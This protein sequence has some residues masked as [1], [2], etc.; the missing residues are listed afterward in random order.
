VSE[1]LQ[2]WVGRAESRTDTIAAAP[3]RMLAGT[4]DRDDPEPQ[5][6]DVLPPLWHWLSFLPTPRARETGA[7]GHPRR[8]GFLPPVELP[9]RMWAAGRL[10]WETANPLR[11]G[12]AVRRDSAIVSVQ[13]KEGRSGPLVFVTVRHRLSNGA[14]LA[15]SEEQ[16]IVYRDAPKAGDPPPAPTAAAQ[17]APWRRELVPDE[18]MLFRYSAL[19]FN[20][21]RIHYDRPYAVDVEGYPALVV[22]GPL[23]AML[24]VDLLRCQAPRARLRS[25]HF[26]A[27]R[28]C[29][30]G[31][32]LRLNGRPAAEGRGIGLWTEDHEGRLCMK[33]GAEIEP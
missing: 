11:I 2:D 29:F 13:R 33:A 30:D 3:V 25:F 10:Q 21:H 7:D 5:P 14:G 9:R 1:D 22:Q 4:L 32:A 31:R 20:G 15:L 6:G 24:L 23:Q 12:D 18:V 17:D 28:P 27:L 19:T 26:Q 16:D 8:G